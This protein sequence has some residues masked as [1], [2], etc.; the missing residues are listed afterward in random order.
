MNY[1]I[2]KRAPDTR[3]HTCG[4][5]TPDNMVTVAECTVYTAPQFLNLIVHGYIVEETDLDVGHYP[6][7]EY[8][9]FGGRKLDLIRLGLI[10]PP[11]LSERASE[12]AF[13]MDF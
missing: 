13:S 1:A 9:L 12:K 5:A 8:A 11:K 10:A 6:E 3:K 7:E 2:R 4:F